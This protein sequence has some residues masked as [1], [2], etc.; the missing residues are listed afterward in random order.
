MNTRRNVPLALA[1]GV[2]AGAAHL[3]AAITWGPVAETPTTLSGSATWSGAPSPETAI[4]NTPGGNWQVS[5]TFASTLKVDLVNLEGTHL[6]APHATD[7]A[8]GDTIE[9]GLIFPKASGS[10]MADGMIFHNPGASSGHKDSWVM[11]ASALATGASVKFTANHGIPEPSTYALVAG[12]GL[13]G[14][15]T[16][17][18]LR[19]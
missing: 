6:V 1:I 8:P 9:L 4:L 11:D 13:L 17:R 7:T 19:R 16:L 2:L 12:L 3:H 15:A 14:F 10:G 18:R 5:L